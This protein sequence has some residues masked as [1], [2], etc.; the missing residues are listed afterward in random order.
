MTHIDY[1]QC[2]IFF[3]WKFRD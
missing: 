1:I 2:L 3:M